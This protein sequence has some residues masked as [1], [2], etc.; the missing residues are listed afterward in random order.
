[1]GPDVVWSAIQR[2]D[3]YRTWW[4]WLRGFEAD[5]FEEGAVWRCVV[6]PP[7][8]Y[9]LRFTITLDTVVD[10]ESAWATVDGEITG[11]ASL[12]VDADRQGST[13]RLVSD[14]APA[15]PLLK[16]FA[17]AARPLVVWGHDWVLDRGASQ[18]RQRGLST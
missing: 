18:F 3:R 11:K 14:L 16:G 9:S 7:L 8:P 2:T 15:S 6:Q 1:V 12:T 13:I 4:P 10:G 17:L 5:G